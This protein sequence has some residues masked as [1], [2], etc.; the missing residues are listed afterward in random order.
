MPAGYEAIRDRFLS[1]GMSAAEAKRRAAR[2][3]N[4]K[5]RGSEAV[6]RHKESAE[7]RHRES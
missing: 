3:W 2:I 7:P 5:H 1:Q 6:G 4:S